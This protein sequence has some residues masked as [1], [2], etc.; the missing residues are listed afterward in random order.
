MQSN[1]TPIHINDHLDTTTLAREHLEHAEAVFA[2]IMKLVGE[3]TSAF[4]LARLGA[5]TAG[6]AADDFDAQAQAMK[7][8][9][10]SQ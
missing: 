2:G 3:D 1:D 5:L 4:N 6:Q 8:Q 9:E 7:A 10:T